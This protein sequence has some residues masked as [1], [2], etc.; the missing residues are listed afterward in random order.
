MLEVRETEKEE[1]EKGNQKSQT[2][3]N[4]WNHVTVLELVTDSSHL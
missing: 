4:G 1:E 2:V 3:N